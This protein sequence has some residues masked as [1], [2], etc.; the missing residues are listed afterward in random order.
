[1]ASSKI[2]LL[3]IKKV[4]GLVQQSVPTITDIVAKTGIQNIGTPNVQ[5]P[6]FCQTSDE[7]QK[8]LKLRNNLINKL[9]TTYKTIESLQKAL[10]PI[11]TIINT[12]KTG[13]KV[14][15]TALT[16]AE[17]AMMITPPII[18]IP[19]PVITG[20][21]KVNKLV[22][23]TIPPIITIA[24][25]NI[26]FITTALDYAGRV[27]F[28]LLSLLKSIDQYLI[29]CG[30]STS[31]LTPTSDYINNINQQYIDIQNQPEDSTV[32]KGFILEIVE[33]PYSPTVTRRKA[34]AKNRSNIILLQTPLSFTTDNQTLLDSIK[35]LIDSNDLKAD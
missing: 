33:E 1:M 34:I 26:T 14:A 6:D 23:I 20:Y 8:I 5:M 22:N 17:I 4:E 13:L 2:P 16:A 11:N 18:P 21:V 31:E 30:I 3:I 15:K 10:N 24:S 28:I 27:V 32:Y 35:L 19:G 12:A 7:L 9:N 29:G 25:N